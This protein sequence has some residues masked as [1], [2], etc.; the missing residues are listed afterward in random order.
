[1]SSRLIGHKEADTSID[2]VDPY[3]TYNN[4]KGLVTVGVKLNSNDD[5]KVKLEKI[6]TQKW[7]ANF[8]M[9]LEAWNDLRRTGYPRIFLLTILETA[10]WAKAV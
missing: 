3:D 4:I 1:M 5:P 6:I 7:L 8:P 9:G 2:Y 10:R